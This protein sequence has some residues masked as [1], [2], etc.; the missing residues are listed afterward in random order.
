MEN[1]FGISLLDVREAV[2]FIT[3]RGAPWLVEFWSGHLGKLETRAKRL[4]P[5]LHEM[6]GKLDTEWYPTRT[7]LHIPLMEGLLGA[8][9][10]GEEGGSA[11]SACEG[12]PDQRGE[13][14]E[15]GVY[16]TRGL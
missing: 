12:L 8:H 16:P 1:S 2:R 13:L 4:L 3:E 5:K 6:R 7:R 9:D 11:R 14:A 10:M 15:P